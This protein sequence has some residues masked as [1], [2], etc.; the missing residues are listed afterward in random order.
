MWLKIDLDGIDFH[1][2][3]TNYRKRDTES[4]YEQWCT[5]DITLQSPKWLDYQISSDILLSSE[6]EDIRDS[7][8][9]LLQG[10][11]QEMMLNIHMLRPVM[12]LLMLMPI[13]VF[14]YGMTVLPKI[15]YHFA[16]IDLIWKN[17]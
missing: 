16:L 10:E 2:R 6:I 17:C 8:M 13:C 5:V 12:R 14:T 9:R 15:I 4:W 1:F 7:I 3:I 11:I